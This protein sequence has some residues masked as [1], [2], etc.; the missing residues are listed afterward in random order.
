MRNLRRWFG[1]YWLPVS[2]VLAEAPAA[3][4]Q[5]V[6]LDDVTVVF[7]PAQEKQAGPVQFA[8]PGGGIAR[9]LSGDFLI[10]TMLSRSPSGMRFQCTR[11]N[12]AVRNKPAGS[13]AP[14]QRD[15]NHEKR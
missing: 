9:R 7:A 1:L 3:L 2:L 12:G 11:V 13:A 5:P 8:G 6:P 4:K 10:G 14:Q 15:D